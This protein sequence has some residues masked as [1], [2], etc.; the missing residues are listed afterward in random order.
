MRK[1]I[2]FRLPEVLHEDAVKL[3]REL[4]M[5]LNAVIVQALWDF[6]EKKRKRT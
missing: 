6:V 4:G 2:L 1:Q 3:A 5:S